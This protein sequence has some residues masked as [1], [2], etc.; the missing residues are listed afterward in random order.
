MAN[1]G[2]DN[3]GIKVPPPLIYLLPLVAGLLLDRKSHVAFLPRGVG[4]II[5]WPLVVGGSLLG[6]WFRRTMRDADAPVRTD[7]PV[8]RLTTDGPFRYTRNPGYLA[9][10]MIYAGIAVLR[11]TLWPIVLLPAVLFVIQREVIGREE[12]YLERTFGEEYLNYKAS[13]RRWV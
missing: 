2:Q 11:N 8:P 3:P 10:A 6:G 9:L 12:R 1:D 4:R 5:G 13:V 7:K